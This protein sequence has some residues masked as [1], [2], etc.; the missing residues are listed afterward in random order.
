MSTIHLQQTELG[1][2][3]Y[4]VTL[5]CDAP[6]FTLTHSSEFDYRLPPTD[7]EAIRWYLE[8][9]LEHP[10]EPNPDIAAR[11]E[12]RMA[13]LGTELFHRIF[14]DFCAITWWG[15]VVNRLAEF[16][17]EISTSVAAATALPWEL[18]RDPQS[19]MPVALRAAE[20]VRSHCAAKVQPPIPQPTQRIRLLLAIC[21]PKEDRDVPFRSVASQL[22][23]GLNAAARQKIELT[24]LRPPTFA[25]LSRVLRDAHERGQPFHVLH[26]DG[27]GCYADTET[28]QQNL[29]PLDALRFQ[30][31]RQGRHGYLLFENPDSPTNSDYIDGARL[32]QLLNACGVPVLV[33]NACRSAH[34]DGGA[35][36]AAPLAAGSETLASFGVGGATPAFGSLAQ[37]VMDAGVA[38]VVAMRYNLWVVTA[39]RFVFELYRNLARGLG[40]G[41]AVSRG[42][43]QLHAEPRRRI[44]YQDIPLQDW[45]VPVVFEAA[46]IRLFP[47]VEEAQGWRLDLGNRQAGGQESPSPQPS[48]KGTGGMELPPPPDIGFIGR[49]ETLLALD[50]AFDHHHVVLLHAYAGS[51]K[52]ATAAEFARWYRQTGGLA[53]GPVL[54]TA[55][56]SYRPLYQVLGDFGAVFGPL[57]EQH[58]IH[59]GALVELEQRRNIALQ[60]MAQIPLLWVWDN[61]EPVA[62]F[63]EG[64]ESAWSSAEQQEL[65]RFL[66]DAGRTQAKLLL[67]SRRRETAWLG[68][69]PVRVAVPPMPMAERAAFA[70]ALAARLPRRLAVADWRPLLLFSGGNP[71]TLQVLLRQALEQGLDNRAAIAA[72]VERLRAGEVDFADEASERRERSLAAAL[73]YGFAQAFSAAE[74]QV[75]ALLVFFQGFVDVDVLR[76]MGHPE[77]D[78]RLPALAGRGREDLLPLLERAA[79]LGLLESL[80]GGYYRIHPALPW[81]FRRLFQRHYPSAAEVAAAER[82]FVAALGELGDYYHRQYQAGQRAVIAA[83]RAEEANLLY[84]WRLA[85]RLALWP[86]V[87]GPMQGLRTLYDHSGRRAEWA[88]LVAAILPDFVADDDGPLPGQEEQWNLVTQYRAQL[89]QEAHD[90]AAAER[91][92]RRSVEWDRARAAPLLVR[93]AE[94]WNQSERNRLRSLAVALHQLGQIQRQQEQPECVAAY[95]EALGLSEKIGDTPAAATCAFNLGHVYYGDEVSVLRDLERAEHWYR[96]SL[97]LRTEEDRQGRARCLGQLGALAWERVEEAVAAGQQQQAAIQAQA[98]LEHYHQ[99]LELLPADAVADLSAVHNQLGLIYQAIGQL[100][101]ALHHYQEDIRLCDDSGDHYGAAQTRYNVALALHGAGRRADALDY[102]RAALQGYQRYGERAQRNIDKTQALIRMIEAA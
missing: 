98:A 59:W 96:R 56:E 25:Q 27:H 80:G 81:F 66:A 31:P 26:F 86:L 38:G 89:A 42:R 74:Q 97:E 14:N 62:G 44:A 94:S 48:P 3:R 84:A 99:A 71:L 32:G 93:S 57:L 52:T 101:A 55:F 16:R 24:V 87:I 9:Y 91:L 23:R 63:P 60:V 92:Q 13:E 54:F 75:L 72:F 67:T 73:S 45:P 7:Q 61:V 41:A 85:R 46:P 17:V 64:S 49:D 77:A 90:W 51:G 5:C 83:L 88:A 76:T 28:L 1:P 21:R 65:R 58:G 33:L 18:L 19:E 68:D 100:D 47:P 8:D 70:E 15:Q 95:E 11:C 6:G 34:A 29:P 4:R 22:V 20:F 82:A 79:G 53:D 10:F 102:A 2:D 43:K 69:V 40:L 39:T 78:W 37:E 35:T 12:T 50:R 36:E 30:G